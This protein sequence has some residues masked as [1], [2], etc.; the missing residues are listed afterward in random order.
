M[1]DWITITIDGKEI[2]AKP[3]ELLVDAAARAGIHIP[4]F[5]YH[6]KLDP[7][8]ACRMCL[9]EAEGRRG[10]MLIT[11]CTT[12]V[13]DGGVYYYESERA[14]DARQ[15]TLEL[16]LIN[17]PLDCPICDKG[18]ECPLQDQTL[19][20]GPGKSHFWEE[21]N[22][23]AKHYPLSDLIMLDQERCI[24][25]WRCIR[26]LEEWEDKP[27]LGLF[28]RGGETVI[29]KFPDGKLDAYTS[30]SIIDI[31]PVGAL[32]NRLA[33]F[34]YRPWELEKTPSICTH[35]GMGCNLRI[36]SRTHRIRRNV[37][38]ENAAVND[39]WICDKGRFAMGFAS[40]PER[41]QEPLARINGELRPV[42][43]PEALDRVVRG[44][45][46]VV[47]THGPAAVAAIGSAKLS[48][49]ANYLL[50]KFMRGVVGSNNLDFR[51]GSAVVADPRGIPSLADARDADV[52]VLMGC[53]PGEEMPVLANFLKRAVLRGGAKMI[54][55]HPR[56]IELTQYAAAFIN[57]TIGA[58][59][60]AF[61]ALTRATLDASDAIIP[62]WLP[63]VEEAAQV[64][65]ISVE[66]VREAA[67]LLSQAK[68]PFIVYGVD[69][70]WG[71]GARNLVTALT[72]WVVAAGHGER[73]GFLH[74]Q[75]NALGAADMGMA[76]DR[77]PGHRPLSDARARRELEARWQTEI[78]TQPGLSYG[79]M[80]ASTPDRIRALYLMGA[81][82]VGE[83]PADAKALAEL[84]FLVVQDMFLTE[85]AKLAD[86]VLPAASYAESRGTFTNTERRVQRAPQA[87]RTVGKSVADWAI[88]MHLARRYAPDKKDAW[89]TPSVDAIFAE[90]AEVVP[91]YRGMSW[92]NLGESGQQWPR[93]AVSL[94][95]EL[96]PHSG[97]AIPPS[98]DYPFRLVVG[99]LLWD[100]GTVFAAT[101]QMAGLARQAAWLHPDDAARLGVQ[102]GDAIEIRSRGGSIRT[103]AHLDPSIKPG[104][105]FAPYSFPAAP[106]G[107]LFDDYVPRTSVAIEKVT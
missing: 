19:E 35:C 88:L 24:V 49:E 17:H 70:A 59:S 105:V 31:C 74:S 51:E 4:V 56:A 63:E 54:I 5:C 77:L 7:L 14:V 38:R 76:P 92:E 69:Y 84:D 21:K 93:D 82:P 102:E 80:M 97:A 67:R 13:A 72:N 39:E 18:G 3:G 73:L 94:S 58:E 107:N 34:S 33:R 37:A 98:P 83:K 2:Q 68:R 50:A 85:S 103:F 47:E 43:W 90:I 48:N 8:G 6:P 36:D 57:P 28:H 81:D 64:A 61:D 55:V 46:R 10:K 66:D 52:I 41:L 30:G 15:G 75:A 53:D 25:C 87:V 45:K 86:V 16:I 99:S 101:P 71:Y 9:V 11:A 23:K 22:H 60:A 27:Q 79:A 1:S 78:P 12:P 62:D 20:H 91:A 89:D 40:H 106:V 44:L 100:G 32:T 26:Y 42:S 29:D 96:R 65:G 95:R 104:S